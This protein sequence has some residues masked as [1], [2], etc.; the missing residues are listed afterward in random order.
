MGGI[1]EVSNILNYRQ[2][3]IR[4]GITF[5]D[6]LLVP[7]KGILPSRKLADTSTYITKT[8]RLNI[9]LISSNMATVTEARMA[10]AMARNGGLGVIHQFMTAEQEAE[11]VKKFDW[12]IP[13]RKCA[14]VY[15]RVLQATSITNGGAKW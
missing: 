5:D 11:E 6:V 4:E 7:K 15:R 3:N 14:D 12:N 9:P 10:I 13:A 2:I 8:I 1:K